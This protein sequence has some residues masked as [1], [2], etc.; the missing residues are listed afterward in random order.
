M[1]EGFRVYGLSGVCVSWEQSAP[2]PLLRKQ[3]QR[4]QTQ[5][6][7]SWEQSAPGRDRIAK[8]RNF[9]CRWEIPMGD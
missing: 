9:F 7:V 5:Y 1:D 6:H 4:I 8:T 2:D 3:V